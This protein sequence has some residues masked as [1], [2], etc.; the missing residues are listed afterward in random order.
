MQKIDIFVFFKALEYPKSCEVYRTENSLFVLKLQ[1][2]EVGMV[3]IS[4][5][6]STMSSWNSCVAGTNI[7]KDAIFLSKN[8]IFCVFAVF[9]HFI[10]SRLPAEFEKVTEAFELKFGPNMP[11]RVFYERFAAFFW[12]KIVNFFGQKCVKV[13]HF[14]PVSYK[15]A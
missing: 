15:L 14:W 7:L 5:S 10:F 9:K 11:R 1:L 13:C 12:K 4:L 3:Q 8:A 2:L 6:K